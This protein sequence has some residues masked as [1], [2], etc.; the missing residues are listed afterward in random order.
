M[1]SIH[2]MCNAF[3]A[4]RSGYHAWLDRRPSAR[5]RADAVLVERI[6]AIHKAPK[7]T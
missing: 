6:K 2:A 3:D 1:F 4:S 5:A 7:E